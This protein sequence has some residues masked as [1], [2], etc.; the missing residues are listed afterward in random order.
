MAFE[1]FQLPVISLP[2]ETD[3]DAPAVV[4]TATTSNS[5]T[6]EEDADFSRDQVGYSGTRLLLSNNSFFTAAN[7]SE[8]TVPPTDTNDGVYLRTLVED[9]INVFEVNRKDCAK[10][11]LKD[12][13]RWLPDGTFKSST[14]SSSAQQSGNGGTGEDLMDLNPPSESTYI[15]EN[16]LLESILS[17]IFATPS[18]PKRAIYYHSLI[19]ELCKVSPQTVAPSLGK[20]IRKLFSGLGEEQTSGSDVISL[21]AEGVRRYAEW[22]SVHL[23]NFGFHWRWPEWEASLEL[24][25]THP[26]KIFISRVLELE[27]RLSYFDRIKVTLPDSYLSSS[28][29]VFSKLPPGPDFEYE[30]EGNNAYVAQAAEV[31]RLMRGRATSDEIKELLAGYKKDFTEGEIGDVQ[32][33]QEE[34]DRL[35]KD[36]VFQCVLVIGSRSFSHFLNI[37]ERYES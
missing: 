10:I 14:N 31:Q 7:E 26:K 6:S 4:V 21:N 2:P 12:L 35:A 17:Q 25:S 33:S 3:S 27:I 22:F 13:V 32:L 16:L 24:P 36:L 15:L 28:S 18:S 5:A 30:A 9:I 37:L 8:S 11:L 23:S 34:A 20:C 29:G 1:P 19:A